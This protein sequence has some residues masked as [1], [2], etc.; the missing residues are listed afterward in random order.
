VEALTNE[1]ERR[2]FDYIKKIDEMGGAVKAVES[3][4]MEEEIQD[5]AYRFQKAVEAQSQVIVGMNRFQVEEDLPGDILRVDPALREVQTKRLERTRSERDSAAVASALAEL[6]RAA[7][8]TDNLMPCI[9]I[10][11]KERS[12]L[13]EICGVLR[14]VFGEYT[15]GSHA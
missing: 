10:A 5:S 7:Q 11:V 2:A 12:T 1:I 4:Y 14:E 6:K 8:G 15:H 13:G 3:G 9:M